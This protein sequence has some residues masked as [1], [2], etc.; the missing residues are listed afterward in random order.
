MAGIN[1]VI[2]IGNLG[3]APEIRAMQNGDTVANFSVATSES[4]VDKNTQ[5]IPNG[6]VLC[7]IVDWPTSQVNIYEKDR[8]FMLRE[9]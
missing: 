8:K 4:W 1:K 9:N 7:F 6:T 2:I 3:N 5:E